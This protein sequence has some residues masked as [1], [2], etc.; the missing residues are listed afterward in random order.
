MMNYL[1]SEMGAISRTQITLAPNQGLLP[2]GCLLHFDEPQNLHLAY[3]PDP[4][5]NHTAAA[6]LATDIDTDQHTRPLAD[7][8]LDAVKE[9]H[10]KSLTPLD[11]AQLQKVKQDLRLHFIKTRT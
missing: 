5:A 4:A 1:L 9:I 7:D 6:I 3:D 10:L 11:A 2:E 8:C